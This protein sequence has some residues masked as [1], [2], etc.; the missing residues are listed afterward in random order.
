MGNSAWSDIA[1]ELDV[2]FINNF[3]WLDRNRFSKDFL[4]RHKKLK[5]I[6]IQGYE[7]VLSPVF[8][9]EF[10][11]AD[12]IVKLVKSKEKIGSAGDLSN[13]K[14]W[15]KKI[16]DKYYN[17]LID[18][19]SNLMFEF[20]RNKEFFENLLQMRL[21]I[22]KPHI[23][24]K[25]RLLNFDLPHKYAVLFIGGSSNFRKWNIEGFAQ[26]GKYLKEKYA[27]EI[28][29]CGDLSDSANSLKFNEYFNGE[30]IDLV[31]KTSLVDLLH[32][33]DNANLMVSNDTS[34][35]HF[36]SALEMNNIFTIYNGNHY[37]R[38]I[39][40]PKE[41][42]ENYYVIYHPEIEKDLDNYE[43]ISNNYGYRSSLDINEISVES[44]KSKI[45]EALK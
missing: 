34:A 2:E 1:K 15:Q 20:N 37:G 21:D 6:T 36:A 17:N 18:V 3:I 14:K 31:G 19:D 9:R 12:T 39:P 16:S 42:S 44:I 45:D 7:I 29:L 10:F 25:P 40:Y 32:I 8:S 38:F 33:I 23:F 28:T 43:K 11:Y 41:V 27:Y 26:I 24:L 22:K 13:I 4:Y 35:P 5:E 30:Y